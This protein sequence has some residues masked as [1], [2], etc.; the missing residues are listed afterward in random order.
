[1]LR[2]FGYLVR[3]FIFHLIEFFRHWYV[4]AFL[5]IGRWLINNLEWFDRTLAFKV[6]LRHFF[7][8]L[9]GDYT[10]LGRFLGFL[11]RFIRIVLAIFLYPILIFAA[12][13]IYIIWAVIPPFIFIHIFYPSLFMREIDN[14]LIWIQM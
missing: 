7:E 4:N 12:S 11:F 3:H 8:P 9:Y 10:I 13:A 1:M 5:V 2:A 14:A 6:T